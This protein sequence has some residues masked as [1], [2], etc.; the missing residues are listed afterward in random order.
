MEMEKQN[1]KC[2]YIK[3]KKK[4]PRIYFLILITVFL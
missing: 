2:E 4:S 3:K 1:E